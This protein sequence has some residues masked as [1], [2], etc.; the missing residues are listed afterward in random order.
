MHILYTSRFITNEVVV[1]SAILK[2]G[3][4]RYCMMHDPGSPNRLVAG[5]K[6]TPKLNFSTV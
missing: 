4:L 2:V 3:K 6:E 5:T 1:I